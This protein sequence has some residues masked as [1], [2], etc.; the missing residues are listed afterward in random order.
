MTAPSLVPNLPELMPDDF[1]NHRR[2]TFQ[3]LTFSER[4]HL[5]RLGA[6][7]LPGVMVADVAI[8]RTDEG[9]TFF[10][11]LQIDRGL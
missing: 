4:H 5:A 3:E 1:P 2:V 10:G 11:P 7:H 8:Y 6:Q 9:I